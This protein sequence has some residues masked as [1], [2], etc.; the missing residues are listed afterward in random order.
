M[1]KTDSV[2]DTLW[3]RTIFHPSNYAY[4]LSSSNCIYQTSDGGY[5]LTGTIYSITNSTDANII[6]VK[7]DSFGDTLWTRIIGSNAE[8]GGGGGIQ[9]SDNGYIIGGSTRNFGHGGTDI[10]LVKTDASGF[11]QWTKTFG[12]GNDD[13]A[14]Y[15][16][17]TSDGGYILS[18]QEASW[19]DGG[20]LYLL[21][22]DS[23]GYAP[24]G[25]FPIA[26]AQN[27]ILI[28]PNPLIDFAIVSIKGETKFPYTLTLYDFSGRV[29]RQEEI[30]DSEYTIER[31]DLSTGIYFCSIKDRDGK[32]LCN[33]KIIIQ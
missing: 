33:R 19:G 28:Y 14:D 5:F 2:G 20:G 32:I 22:T 30:T 16:T 23:S 6:I 17:S 9:T 8:G 10:W 1:I 31:N 29:I 11:V 25:F 26:V 7:T 24:T 4:I 21:K 3:T 18:G 13:Y 27:Q 15:I 12:G